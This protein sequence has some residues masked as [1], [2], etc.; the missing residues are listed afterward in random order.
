MAEKIEIKPFSNET[1]LMASVSVWSILKSA[2]ADRMK[3]LSAS[4]RIGH[5]R[6]R[7]FSLRP[8]IEKAS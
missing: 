5:D 2:L 3:K 6:G 1:V 4:T 7:D 8:D